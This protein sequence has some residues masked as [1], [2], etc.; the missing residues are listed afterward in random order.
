[1]DELSTI[2]DP[3]LDQRK[4]ERFESYVFCCKEDLKG[5]ESN[6]FNIHQ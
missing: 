1:M 2:A 6:D 3:I 5:K 4:K